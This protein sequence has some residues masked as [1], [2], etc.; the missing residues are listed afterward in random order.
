MTEAM[1]A[2]TN[3]EERIRLIKEGA[4]HVEDKYNNE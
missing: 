3:P 2:A 4:K 1:K